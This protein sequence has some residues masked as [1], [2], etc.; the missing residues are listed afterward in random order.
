MAHWTILAR[1]DTGL[2]RENNED[3]F[4]LAPESGL[5]VLADGMGG[6]AAG[7]VASRLAVDILMQRLPAHLGELPAP[8]ALLQ[9]FAEANSAVFTAAT[10]DPA[11]AGMGTTA[12][13]ALFAPTTVHLAHV[14]DSRA[15]RLRAGR[16]ECLT[17]DHTVAQQWVARGALSPDTARHSPYRHVLTLALGTEATV[18]PTLREEATQPAD[19]YLLCSDGLTDM[20]ADAAIEHL[21]IEHQ[22]D[23]ARAAER[24]I[25]AANAAGGAD[26]ITVVLARM[27]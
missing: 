25:E 14:G 16:L 4:A 9:A 22:R 18:Q 15:Y 24:L 1:T 17:E 20:L 10:H 27:D 12:V 8:Q 2:V 19:L 26:N 3:N 5:A 7:E 23:L 21:L 13:T 11:C 6:H